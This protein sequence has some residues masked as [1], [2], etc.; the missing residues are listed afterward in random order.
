M[1]KIVKIVVIFIVI[2][3]VLIGG[4]FAYKNF[5]SK[6]SQP[7]SEE[8]EWVTVDEYFTPRNYVEEFIKNDSAEKEIFPVHIRNYGKSA[9]ILKRF[10]GSEFARPSEAQLNMMY[11]GLEDW[12]LVDL[13]FKSK[14][15]K[16]IIRSVL[17]IY[18]D[19]A[20]RVGDSGKLME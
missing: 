5:L 14:E 1:N 11:R 15:D 17:Y 6:P 2:D 16:E 8:Y 7:L 13:K 9:A 3:I 12:M 4:Y 18:L 20:W 10:R 19:G